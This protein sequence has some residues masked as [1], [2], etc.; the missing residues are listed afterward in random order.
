MKASSSYAWRLYLILLLFVIAF[1]TVIWRLVDLNIVSRHFLLKQSQ[2]RILRKVT[3]AAFRGMITDRD[4]APLAISTPVDSIWINPKIF[5]AS[6]TQLAALAKFTQRTPHYIQ[7]RFRKNKRREFVYIRRRLP[8]PIAAQIHAL[9]IPGVFSQREYKRYYPE[10]EVA[11]HVVGLT[12][13]D[14]EGQEGLE[15]AFNSWLSGVPGL[16]EVVKDRLGYIVTNVALLKKP[17][18]GKNLTL[19]IDHRIQ[20]LAYQTLKNTVHQFHAVSGSLIVLDVK[21]G[22]ILADVNQPSYNPNNRPKD[23]D[24]RYRNRAVTD[25]FEPGSVIKP[26]TIVLALESGK[27]TPNT[28]IDTRPGWMRVGG[29]KIKDDGYY[30]IINLTTVLKKSSNV[31]A[32][33][34]MLS[35]KPQQYW[36]LLRNFGFGQRTASGFPGE[37]SGVLLPRNVWYPSEVATLAYGYGIAVTTLQLAAA[38]AILANDGIKIPITFLKREHPVQGTRV[39]SAADAKIVLGMLE[40]VVQKGGTG[41]RASVS[42]YR[43]AGKTGTAYIADANGYNKHKYMAS[44]VGMAPVSNPQLVIAVVVRD[45]KGKHFGGLV[46][47]PAFAK[48]MAGALRI[49][50]IAPDNLAN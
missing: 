1:A 17:Q 34:I 46:A 47:A 38:Y 36:D 21:T 18:Q 27:Y 2:A 26:F 23:H 42:G 20:Y 8:P 48:V 24:G 30:G 50:N 37:A 31:G 13:V 28:L 16:K 4:G 10:G 22:E 6:S 44:F 14:D 41:T 49:M 15:L 40:T 12:N 33:K 25:T 7:R 3:M 19:S 5:K 9:K 11:A 43:V 29:Y 39:I 45:P 35:L 32:A